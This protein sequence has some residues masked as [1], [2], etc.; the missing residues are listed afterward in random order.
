M[1]A[2]APSIH[3]TRCTRYTRYTSTGFARLRTV[4][5]GI[6]VC[7]RCKTRC[8]RLVSSAAKEKITTT[9]RHRSGKVMVFFSDILRIRIVAK[10]PSGRSRYRRRVL[11]P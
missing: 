11:G 6:R 7:K 9:E 2:A 4:A 5:S 10:T 8:S 3:R 1:N